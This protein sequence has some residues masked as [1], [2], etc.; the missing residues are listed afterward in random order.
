MQLW[1][2]EVLTQRHFEVTNKQ[3]KVQTCMWLLHIRSSHESASYA[4][5]ALKKLTNKKVKIL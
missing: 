2:C 1:F 3:V 5:H 4:F